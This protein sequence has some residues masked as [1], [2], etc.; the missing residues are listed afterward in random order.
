MRLSTGII[1]SMLS[2]NAFAIEH[3]ND[4]HPGSLLARR[5]VV[6]DTDGPSL[7]KRND[8][9]EQEAQAKTKTSVSNPDS[10]QA[11]NTYENLAFENDPDS[12]PN[13]SLGT[14]DDPT[15][16][17]TY[18]FDQG[19]GAKDEGEDVHTGIVP[20]Q[21]GPSLTDASQ[22]SSSQALDHIKKVLFRTKLEFE[23]LY[24][25][26]KSSTACERLYRQFGSRNGI[27]I[28][29][30]LYSM[31]LYASRRSKSY[32][33][34]CKD[35]VKSPFILEFPFAISDESKTKY[36]S[37]QNEVLKSIENHILTVK[38]T[39]KLIIDDPTN[40]ILYL[41]KM[42]SSAD[43]LHISISNMKSE[44]SSLLASLGISGYR[45]LAD[46]D[47][48]IQAVKMYKCKLFEYFSNIKGLIGN[49]LR[50]LK[51]K[52][53]LYSSPSMLGFKECSEIENKLS[54]GGASGS[55]QPNVAVVYNLVD[56]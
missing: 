44:H 7:Q 37:L 50:P 33:I 3:L 10:L 42:L 23:L 30:D 8:G 43:G 6:A 16:L 38:N 49:S 48:H 53:P 5:A 29:N 40:V 56:L 25:R 27:K 20:N 22:G 32:R 34:M 15:N 14:G 31:L 52:G 11:E 12:S 1:L 39:I 24:S 54:E 17:C 45:H 13:P 55:A 2:A 36:K 18:F 46:L 41:E 47:M 51:R 35:P 26:Q 21:E 9:K 4:A 28:S 19:R